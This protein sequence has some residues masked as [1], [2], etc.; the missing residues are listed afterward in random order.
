LVG[1]DD[2]AAHAD[3]TAADSSSSAPGGTP[4]LK[5]LSGREIRAPTT[6]ASTTRRSSRSGDG[7]RVLARRSRPN[8]RADVE[9]KRPARRPSLNPRPA[10]RRDAGSRW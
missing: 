4:A 10:G 8:P 7:H 9:A 3:G 5:I 1:G 2:H 6:H